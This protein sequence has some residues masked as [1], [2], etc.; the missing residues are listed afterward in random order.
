MTR[1]HSPASI[2]HYNVSVIIAPIF[3]HLL[4][5]IRIEFI[6]EA[7]HKIWTQ[8]NKTYVKMLNLW[9]FT[10][11]TVKAYGLYL[12]FPFFFLRNTSF[13]CFLLW[14]PILGGGKESLIGRV[15][16]GPNSP[17][18][19]SHSQIVAH[20]GICGRKANTYHAIIPVSPSSTNLPPQH[21]HAHLLLPPFPISLSVAWQQME[22]EGPCGGLDEWWHL[23]RFWKAFCFCS[24]QSLPTFYGG[25]ERSWGPVPGQEQALWPSQAPAGRLVMSNCMWL[26][27]GLGAGGPQGCRMQ[28]GIIRGLRHS[29]WHWF[30][31]AIHPDYLSHRVHKEDQV[32]Q[33]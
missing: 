12:F 19:I 8:R 14:Q 26:G 21:P 27:S 17:T 30:M 24:P 28:W 13:Y 29:M 11:F 16:F 4:K 32:P 1:Y 31:E 3:R 23:R 7:R 9:K 33:G 2:C 6:I 15:W 25:E 10:S 22:G 5:K 20:E 18:S